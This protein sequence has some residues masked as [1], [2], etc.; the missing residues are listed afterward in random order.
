[1]LNWIKSHL[2]DDVKDAWKWF[3]V[4]ALLVG[5]G[6]NAAWSLLSPGLQDSIPGGIRTVFAICAFL[7]LIGRTVKQK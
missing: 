1:M 6:I 4:W 5:G 3:S 7:A 2:V